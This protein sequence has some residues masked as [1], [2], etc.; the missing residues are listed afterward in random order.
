MRVNPQNE[1]S[2]YGGIAD[3]SLPSTLSTPVWVETDEYGNLDWLCTNGGCALG[4][5][6]WDERDVG[7]REKAQRFP[8][9]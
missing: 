9:H 8:L 6:S 2:I 5:A 7:E 1:E 4:A 3:F